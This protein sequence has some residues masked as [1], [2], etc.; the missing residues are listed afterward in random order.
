MAFK[1]ATDCCSGTAAI[2]GAP[3]I[4][5]IA[6]FLNGK[7]ITGCCPVLPRDTIFTI[8]DATAP[9]ALIRFDATS[10]TA[11]QTRVVTV[12]DTNLI[13]VGTTIS[14]VLTCKTLTTP[15]I[16]ATGFT[17]MQHTHLA[18]NT[19]G[20]ITEAAIS[21]LQCYITDPTGS[22]LL[23]ARFW[24]GN[25]CNVAVELTISGGVTVANTGVAT[26]VTNANLTGDITSTGNAT[27]I[28]CN[29]VTLAHLAGGTAGN[30]I[31]YDACGDPA[32]VATGNCGQ[33]LTSGGACVAPTF[34]CAGAAD[35]LGNHT[36]TTCLIMGTN[37]IT[38]GVDV[39]APAACVSYHT[40]L[41]AGPVYNA[42]TCDVHDFKINAVSIFTISPTCVNVVACVAF[43]EACIAIS[44]IGTHTQ[45]I[46]AGA[47][48]TV[49]TNGAEF[50]EL[51][52][53]TNDIMLQT[54]NFDTTT[55]EKIQFWW[56]P[57]AEWNAGT[58]TFNAKWTETGG[59]ACGTVIF[60]LAGHSYTDDDAIDTAIC[61][62]A[63]TVTDT[64]KNVDNDM[65]ISPQSTG[66]T[67]S[68]ATKGEAVLLQISRTISDTLDVDAKLIGINITYTTD[69]ATEA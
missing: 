48:G 30:L 38:F 4:V 66:V 50:A 44:P 31:T 46:P 24:I 3:D 49:T 47:W 6:E 1:E 8:S 60:S 67:I 63:A 65:H 12:P 29:V 57:P 59:A 32:A 2:Y 53:V 5:K 17:N 34:A 54:F 22:P 51:E 52:L 36:A 28:D 40:Y 69:E 35:N 14:Q 16:V 68:G 61:G 33:V 62:T 11:G 10:I 58:I 19:G 39:A 26:V 41:A 7:V 25:A 18:A 55:S 37:A 20:T 45:W 56:E 42:I 64:N 9:T 21:D 23:D 13:L 27:L 15:T 43:T